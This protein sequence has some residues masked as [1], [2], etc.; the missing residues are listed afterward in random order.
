MTTVSRLAAA[1]PIVLGDILGWR[2]LDMSTVQRNDDR[3]T[4]LSVTFDNI[5]HIHTLALGHARRHGD[6]LQADV[7]QENI[8]AIF[9]HGCLAIAEGQIKPADGVIDEIY[10]AV[11]ADYSPIDGEW[12]GLHAEVILQEGRIAKANFMQLAGGV[13]DRLRN[14]QD[15]A[16]EY[17]DNT[18]LELGDKYK[19]TVV[20]CPPGEVDDPLLI[21]VA[22][23]G[24][25][26]ELQEFKKTVADFRSTLAI[27]V[28]YL[29]QSVGDLPK[30]LSLVITERV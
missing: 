13:F 26:F 27:V 7:V 9:K 30:S 4:G 19:L 12:L 8:A 25:S 21:V 29:Y 20:F 23:E 3:Q 11:R 2:Y 18:T 5:D 6:D 14:I 17:R 24:V 28:N 10:V 16:W 15:P 22:T 1:N